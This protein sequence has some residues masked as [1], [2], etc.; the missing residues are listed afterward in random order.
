MSRSLLWPFL[1]LVAGGIFTLKSDHPA[2]AETRQRLEKILGLGFPEVDATALKQAVVTQLNVERDKT[3]QQ[4]LAEDKELQDWLDKVSDSTLTTNF[5]ATI[6]KAR[7]ELPRYL[8]L[9]ATLVTGKDQ[10]DLTSQLLT[11]IEASTNKQQLTHLALRTLASN[12]KP[13]AILIAG[14]KL[15]ELTPERLTERKASF[16]F[17]LCP[18][19]HD[20]H[21]CKVPPA[22]RS[23]S[24]DCPKCERCYGMMASDAQGRFRYVNEFLTGYE[25]P[26]LFPEESEPLFTLYT[27][28]K[29]VLTSCIYTE[30]TD[31][32]MPTR[33]IWQTSLET[34]N[35]GRGDCED[36]S[37]LLAD[38]LIKRNIHA[39]VAIGRH[40]DIGGHAWCVAK[41]D[42]IDYLLESTAGKPD[43]THPPYAADVGD[44]YV[45]EILFDRDAIYIRTYPKAKWDGDYWSNKNWIKVQ[46]RLMFQP[47]KPGYTA[48]IA[49]PPE[50]LFRKAP[51]P[52]YTSTAPIKE[53]QPILAQH[54]SGLR[55]IPAG[56]EEWFISNATIYLEPA[57]T[58]PQY[59]SEIQGLRDQRR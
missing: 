5:D 6:K 35:R 30:D 1:L 31:E 47:L 28:W 7:D 23:I 24:L 4:P 41:V 18:H 14:N 33:D 45:P 37:I 54:F 46:P 59:I 36:T 39:R 57:P 16:F 29:T 9:V 2:L 8:E 17:S 58:G 50:S 22:Q 25:P 43:S 13:K 12:G 42:N 51:S 15:F 19:C 34:M 44:R 32:R 11:F 27:I 56:A 20:P 3:K 48:Y 38:W 10:Q 52:V 26:A 55:A 21:A 40:G 53:N 49:A